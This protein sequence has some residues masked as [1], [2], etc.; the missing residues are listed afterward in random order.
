MTSADSSP[1]PILVGG[2]W[3]SDGTPLTAR[4]A[5]D[6]RVI[7]HTFE[8]TPDQ[9][10]RAT[11]AAVQAFSQ[12]RRLASFERGEML[13]DIADRILAD[14]E[15]LAATLAAEIGKPIGDARLEVRRTA[16]AFRMA[17]EE[18]ERIGGE[19]MP[20]DLLPT[21]RGR[22]GITRQ[23][24]LGP[25]A[26][27]SPFNVPLS[28]S[29]H[30]VAPALAAGC[31]VVLKPDSRAAL[32]LLRLAGLIVEAG[33]PAGAVSVLP[34]STEVGDRMVTDDRF[35]M[36]SFTGSV[37]AGWDIRSRAG[38]KKVALELGGNAP[39][40]VDETA[41]VAHAAARTVAAGFKYAGQLCISAQRVFVH[42]AVA[43]EFVDALTK[44]AAALKVGDPLDETTQVG[45]MISV[46][47]ADRIRS[48]IDEAVQGGARLLTG[49]EGSGA[50]VTPA[51]LDQVPDT[52][53]LSCQ[54]AFGPVVVVNTFDDL[55]AAFAA[56][57]GTP[58]GLQAG[59]FTRDLHRAWR[60]YEQLE[61]GTVVINDAPA[62][63]VDSMPFGGVKKSGLGREGIRWAIADMTEPRLLVLTPEA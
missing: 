15:G 33:V 2:R 29:A 11:D 22:W 42:R 63:R 27:I 16:G 1:V 19:V 57:D 38:T 8:A 7:G 31:T 26:A 5:G 24:P 17:G 35:R 49:G 60:A 18:A 61:F 50:F 32:T 30:K 10:D 52:A 56:A 45:P 43:T 41:D 62:F 55:D 59:Y 12:T 36:V 51:V 47:A 6:G 9:L 25:I 53:Q 48:W 58:Y 46:D 23:M 37:Q 54:E 4:A 3:E 28:L 40:I 13:R 39:V 44:G 14:A 20:L 21:S 34:M